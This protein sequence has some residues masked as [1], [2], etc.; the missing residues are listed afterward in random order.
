MNS[1]IVQI[2][3]FYNSERWNAE[4]FINTNSILKESDKYKL[5]K[6]GD[7]LSERK[8][9]LTPSDYEERTFNYIGLENISQNSREL[10]SFEPKN[11]NQI[12]S[13]CKIY[14][15][16]DLLY[17]RLRPKLN[18]CL[19]VDDNLSEGICSTEIFVLVPNL[20]LITPDYI[21][22][23]LISPLVLERVGAITAGAALPRMQIKDFLN[24]EIPVPEIE[25]Q[26]RITSKT[27]KL[28]AIASKNIQKATA[29]L[30]KLPKS[31]VISIESG[32]DLIVDYND[33]PEIIIYN[34]P[35]PEGEF[36][37]RGRKRI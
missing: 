12:K 4:Y 8:E 23:V 33:N 30:S 22:E 28:R 27:K 17:G 19:L 21:A 11:S 29:I 14:R 32:S 7:I 10:V 15:K 18:K 1:E 37:V 35:L 24:L 6:L 25:L 9:F 34:H 36:F 31:L 2:T 20:S 3:D 13:R 26:K 5:V 16:G